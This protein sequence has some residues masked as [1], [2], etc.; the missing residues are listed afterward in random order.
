MHLK[1]HVAASAALS[2]GI[3]A[4]T[5]SG[6]MAVWSFLAGVLPDLDH[7]IDY[8]L[9]YKKSIDIARIFK[10]CHNCEFTKLRLFLHSFELVLLLAV[11]S[12][13][14]RSSVLTAVTLGF[15][16]HMTFDQLTNTVYPPGYFLIYRWRKSFWADHIFTN[17]PKRKVDNGNN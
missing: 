5:A 17:A 9:E 7:I 11:A 8:C 6:K 3:Y 12:Y 1:Q 10:V 16:Q 15:M 4:A 14:T 13:I 2:A